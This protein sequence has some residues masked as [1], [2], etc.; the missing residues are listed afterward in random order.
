MNVRGAIGMTV[1]VVRGAIVRVVDLVAAAL[2]AADRVE[3]GKRVAVS[4]VPQPRRKAAIPALLSQ[5]RFP[6][7]RAGKHV[8]HA[9]VDRLCRR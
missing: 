6:Y 9:P 1:T 5:L 3:I 7:S 8:P 4:R 2:A